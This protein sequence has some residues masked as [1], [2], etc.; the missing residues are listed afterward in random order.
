MYTDLANSFLYMKIRIV[1]KDGTNIAD[2]PKCG[3]VNYP[4]GTMI[5]S[6]EMH[7]NNSRVTPLN[8]E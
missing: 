7:L 1:K 4:H 2:A 3:I 5:K 8:D 6:C